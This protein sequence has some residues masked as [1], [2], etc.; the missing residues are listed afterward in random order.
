MRSL[1]AI[2]IVLVLAYPPTLASDPKLAQEDRPEAGLNCGAA[3]LYVLAKLL[4][5]PLTLNEIRSKLSQSPTQS[6]AM[7]D[8]RRGAE[9][10]GIDLRGVLLA[11]SPGRPL[12]RQ[13]VIAFLN[14]GRS[15]HYVVV[16]PVGHTGHVVQLIDSIN[17]P[18]VVES[19]LLLASPAWTGIAL[20]PHPDRGVIIRS[21]IIMAFVV[22]GL[23][24]IALFARQRWV[25]QLQ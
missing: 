24:A 22:V 16:R 2:G 17:P 21:R 19:E 10:L 23:I 25:P 14:R 11:R 18:E 4:D 7:S 20:S 13:P 12:V 5:H 6:L 3:S 1:C 15:G 8:L 9:Q